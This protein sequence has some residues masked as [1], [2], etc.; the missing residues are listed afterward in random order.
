VYD[1]RRGAQPLGLG[2]EVTARLGRV[3]VRFRH[4]VSNAGL[5]QVP[6][7]ARG[8]HELLQHR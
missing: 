2:R 5:G 7:V 4:Q 3:Q 8:T 1:S 6:S